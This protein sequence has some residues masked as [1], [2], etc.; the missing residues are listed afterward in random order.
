MSTA[1]IYLWNDETA[2]PCVRAYDHGVLSFFS[3]MPCLSFLLKK[4]SDLISLAHRE[5]IQA[6]MI[7]WSWH[8]FETSH[9]PPHLL[10]HLSWPFALV[11]SILCTPFSSLLKSWACDSCTCPPPPAPFAL[12]HMSAPALPFNFCLVT[13]HFLPALLLGLASSWMKADFPSPA[14]SPSPGVLTHRI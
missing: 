9:C 10:Y 1:L 7:E 8:H 3:I 11:S 5:Y 13:P 12:P 2:C 14:S 4:R 6:H